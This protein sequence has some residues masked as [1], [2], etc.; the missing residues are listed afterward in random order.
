MGKF[1]ME[2]TPSGCFNFSLIATNKEKI[3]VSSQ[4]YKSKKSY[5][6]RN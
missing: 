4:V 1:Y 2:K 5:C 6:K 3:C